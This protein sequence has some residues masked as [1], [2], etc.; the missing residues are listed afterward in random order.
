MAL[1]MR[2]STNPYDIP[3]AGLDAVA[4]YATGPYTWTSAGWAIF[5]SRIVPLSIATQAGGVGDIA[6]GEDGDFTPGQ[7]ATW[8]REFKRPNRRAPTSYC[9]RASWPSYV[10]AMGLEL[11]RKVDWWIATLD[12]TTTLFYGEAGVSPPAGIRV[13]AIQNKG[14]E[15][16][17]GHYD[18]SV[19][20]DPSWIGKGAAPQGTPI[21]GQFMSSG[22]I[23]QG[24]PFDPKRVDLVVIDSDGYATRSFNPG[25]AGE[26]DNNSTF[27]RVDEAGTP[28]GGWKDVY[29]TWSANDSEDGKDAW[30]MNI[31]GTAGDGALYLAVV[32][33]TGSQRQGWTKLP[34]KILQA[35]VIT[36]SDGT[37]LSGLV[38]KGEFAAHGHNSGPPV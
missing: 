3:L 11:A 21:G 26:I 8:V 28:K 22:G 29:W 4:G 9:N 38:T 23:A 34:V 25:G 17:G 20:L 2:D 36:S 37:D 13:V 31:F 18:E 15:Q 5:P 7:M 30:R 10:D 1:I 33:W 35:P 14:Q 16:T 6:D 12:G 32:D 24:A 19:I 27:Y